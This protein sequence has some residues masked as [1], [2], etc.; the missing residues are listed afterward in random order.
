MKKDWI[1]LSTNDY[2]LYESKMRK[3]H[4][5]TYNVRNKYTYIYQDWIVI[6]LPKEE[7]KRRLIKNCGKVLE[8]QQHSRHC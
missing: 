1:V 7:W 2:S 4:K 6:F 5:R 3:V 8:N